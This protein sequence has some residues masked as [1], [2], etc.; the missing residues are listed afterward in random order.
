LRAIL[1][2]K[3]KPIRFRQHIDDKLKNIKFS[4]VVTNNNRLTLINYVTGSTPEYFISSIGKA[5]IYFEVVNKSAY[6]THI[7]RKV[8]LINDTAPGYQKNKIADILEQLENTTK[9]NN[10]LWHQKEKLKKV[11]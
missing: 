3:E 9:K 2:K 11:V 10:I 7:D 4:A 1:P 5:N 8:A 6:K